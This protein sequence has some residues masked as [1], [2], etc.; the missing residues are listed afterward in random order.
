MKHKRKVT[1][2]CALL[3]FMLQSINAFAQNQIKGR[4]TASSDKQPL[5]GVSVNVRG[6]QKGVSTDVNGNFV[7]QAGPRDVLVFTAIGFANQQVTVGDRTEINVV[8]KDESQNLKEVVVIGYGSISRDKLTN[9]AVSV[10]ADEFRQGGAR[11]A[12]DLLQGKVAGLNITRSSNNPNSGVSL[13]LRG[14]T[15]VEGSRSPLIVID[16]IPGGNLDLL[17]QDD[18]ESMD[19][20]K[21]GSAA[22]IYGTRAN[23]GVILVTT[24]KGKEGPARFDYSTYFRTESVVKKYDFMTAEEVRAAI[25]AGQLPANRDNADWGGASTNMFDEVVNDNP[26]SQYHNLALSGGTKSTSYRA[27]LFFQDLKGIAKE[28]GRKNYGGR[29]NI[30]Q[31]GL[32]DRLSAQINLA[33]NFNSANMLGNSL[34]WETAYTRLPTQPIYNANGTYWEDLTTTSSNNLVSVLNQQSNNRTQQTSSADAKFTLDIVKGL[35]A[36]V[37]GSLQRDTYT[38]NVYYDINSRASVAGTITPDGGRNVVPRG[39]GYAFKGNRIENDYAFEPTIDY[40][41]RIDDHSINGIVGYSY[42]YNVWETSGMANSGYF[43]DQYD[44]NNMGAGMYQQSDASSMQSEKQ[45]N[46]LI[47]FFGR[48]NY[49]FKDKYMA[50]VILRREGS[51]RFGAN[52][53]WGNF[54]AVS[55]GW[56]I[57]REDFMQG[58]S[59]IDFLKLRAGYGVTGNSG[60]ANYT[61]LI[62]LGTGGFYLYP[63]GVW[64]QTYGPDRNPNPDLKWEEKRELNIGLDFNLFQNRIG[65]SLDVFS[66]KTVDLLG[67]VQNQLPSYITERLFYNIGTIAQSGVELSVNATPVK[68]KDFTW[69]MDVT[70]STVSNKMDK[71]SSPQFRTSDL[72]FGGIG[73]AGALG[74]AIRT[75]E[76]DDIGNF[77][78]KRFA[79]FDDAGNWLFFKRDGSRVTAD[80]IIMSPTDPNTDLAVLGNGIPNYYASWTNTFNYKNFDLRIFLR[81]K[82]DFDILNRMEMT[83]G[84]KT[85]SSNLLTSTFTRHAQLN[86]SDSPAYMY[87]DYFLESGDFVKI[88]EITLGYNFKLKTPHV[89][90][91]RIYATGQNLATFTSYTGNDPDFVNDNGLDPGMDIRNPYPA[92]RSFLVGI[93]VGF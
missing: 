81:G 36:S 50:Q 40:S 55:V 26:V 49:S 85:T 78:G 59:F 73:G 23:G 92:T 34:N 80:Q 10:K 17:Q 67:T 60:Y 44:N 5:P 7:I 29:L 45:D 30:N 52:N 13:Q 16:G 18:I 72:S 69:S 71:Y 19:V 74:D 83:Y 56:N 58:V 88:D 46:T 14:V 2:L 89:K 6:S 61:S 57:S 15:S 1:L 42:R 38:D 33:T 93:Q 4:V 53:K 28:S 54:P 3:V 77:V 48:I 32:D 12:M 68:K 84:N 91:L 64:R 75:R 62:T 87:S 66:R 76:G 22:A 41:T 25:A 51:S 21:D 79:G 43:N 63:D 20:L 27:S 39:T 31:K 35:K 8:M 70:A 82:F 90:N 86:S 11:N 47:A 65:G 37:F 9:A 24:K